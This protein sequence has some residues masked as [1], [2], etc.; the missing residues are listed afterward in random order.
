MGRKE[1]REMPLNF[2]EKSPELGNML[3]RLHDKH[4][5][6]KAAKN[7]DFSLQDELASII[8]D[9][10]TFDLSV[11]EKELIADVL[12][13]LIQKMERHVKRA[14]SE[15]LAT[16]SDVP[17]RMMLH[18]AND[19]IFVAAPVLEHSDVLD[20]Q[21]LVYV[22]KSQSLDHAR[23][24]AKRSAIGDVLI[25]ALVEAND[26][27]TS[28]NLVKNYNVSLTDY[29]VDLISDLA[30]DE[31]ELAGLFIKRSEVSHKII[32]R[33]YQSVGQAVKKEIAEN[34]RIDF[35][36]QSKVEEVVD[37]VV[38][39]FE[40]VTEKNHVK[41]EEDFVK[42]A[43]RLL[44][45]NV[46]SPILMVETL[47][48]GS[49][50]EFSAMLSVYCGLDLEITQAFVRQESG[51]GLAIACRATGISKSDFVNMF[52]LSSRLRSGNIISS[53]VLNKA[54]S[55][56]DRITEAQAKAILNKSRQ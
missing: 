36:V 25:D 49:P 8:E 54:L 27:E 26:V 48:H 14:V 23:V 10:V 37:D 44:T 9:L 51:Q 11:N 41:T 4:T 42:K 2:L 16:L 7:P 18:L 24:I 55:Y 56:Y 35:P 40:D 53:N 39:S 12:M 29:A 46:L 17:L 50:Y 28:I 6:Y 1:Y 19:D 22:V 45:Q 52:L 21:D 34:F 32:L 3:V 20:D 38:I 5:L 13:S 33:L 30:V 47:R 43:E 31:D 15:K